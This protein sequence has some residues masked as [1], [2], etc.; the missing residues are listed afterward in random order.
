MPLFQSKDRKFAQVVSDLVHTNPFLPERIELERDVLGKEFDE[1]SSVW[2]RR[3]ED[4][5]DRANVVKIHARVETLVAKTCEQLTSGVTASEEDQILYRDLVTHLLYYRYWDSFSATLEESDRG[6]SSKT[7]KPIDYWDNFL[8][9]FNAYC[10][11]DS[12]SATASER[13]AHLFAC[14]YQVRRAF[15]HIF[16]F[17]VG[18]SLPTARLRARIWQ[19]IFTHDMRRFRRSLYKQMGDITTLV[20]GPSGTGKELVARAIGMSR[21]LPFDEGKRQFEAD[22]GELFFAVNLSALSPSLIESELFGHRRGSFTG[23]DADRAGWLEEC[24]RLG[25]VFLD[26]IG[27]LDMAIQV[28]LLRVLQSRTFQRLGD[29][30]DL[31]FEGKIVAATNRDLGQ[32]MIEGTFREDL[33]YR[34]CADLITTPSLAEQISDAPE[35]LKN[36]VLFIARQVCADEAPALAAETVEWIEKQLGR[37]YPWPGNVRELEQCVRNIMVRKEY[38]PVALGATSGSASPSA[39]GSA[40]DRLAALL[41]QGELTA[42]ELLQHYCTLIYAKEG[43]YEATARRLKLDRRTVKSKVDLGL[44]KSASE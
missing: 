25:T 39:S 35:D 32:E 4:K 15:H 18:S 10:D 14:L 40:S 7:K 38:H 24:P 5:E 2:N 37:D 36:L 42:E 13:A 28:K 3:A 11:H 12:L 17:V 1:S 27:E 9:D 16:N 8:A 21:Y 29:T 31:R 43:S 23:A 6:E 33:Y 30:A 22:C 34:L 19:S 41:A 44:L 26:E 20:T